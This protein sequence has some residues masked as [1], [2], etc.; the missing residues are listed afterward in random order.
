MEVLLVML[1]VFILVIVPVWILVLLLSVRSTQQHQQTLL[2][3]AW[4]SSHWT[5]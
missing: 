4:L 5:A 2:E 1:A 3:T